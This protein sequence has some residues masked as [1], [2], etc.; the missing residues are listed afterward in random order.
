MP[1]LLQGIVIVLVAA[2][3]SAPLPRASASPDTPVTEGATVLIEFT[4]TVPESRIVIPKNVSQFV[5]G[6]H[7]LLPSLEKALTGLHQGE[8]KRVD[9]S[10]EEG[11]GPYDETK[12]TTMSKDRLPPNAQPGNVLTTEDGT[13]FVVTDLSGP[14]AVVDFNHPLAGKHVVIDVKILDVEPP[15]EGRG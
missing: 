7:Q 5:S 1:R 8:Q 10:A 11:F 6:R 14:E 12:R 9:L 3:L 4:I 15:S 2:G 13:P